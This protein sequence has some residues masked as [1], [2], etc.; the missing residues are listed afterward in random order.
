[1]KKFILLVFMSFSMLTANA[2]KANIDVDLLSDI[3]SKKQDEIKKKVLSEIVVR[4]IKTSNYVSYT[5]LYNMLNVLL[6]EKNK[7]VIQQRVIL[8]MSSFAIGIVTYNLFLKD[9]TGLY[10]EFNF[11]SLTEGISGLSPKAK[12]E[13]E[14]LRTELSSGSINLKKIIELKKIYPEIA[15]K[16]LPG[17]L[18]E[19]RRKVLFSFDYF[20]SKII[21]LPFM[22]EKKLV[23]PDF[24]FFSQGIRDYNMKEMK[25][26][27]PQLVASIDACIA[28]FEEKIALIE[29]YTGAANTLIGEARDFYNNFKGD[30]LR[31]ASNKVAVI[32]LVKLFQLGYEVYKDFKQPEGE[33][34]NIFIAKIGEIIS[35]YVI[36]DLSELETKDGAYHFKIDVEGIILALQ[37]AF[38][39]LNIHISSIRKHTIGVDPFFTIGFNY[40][41]FNIDS[42]NIENNLVPIKSDVG[43]ASEK[44]GIKFI[45]SD[46]KYT[47]SFGVN[48]PYKYRGENRS[49]NYPHKFSFFNKLYSCIYISGILYNIVN[50]KTD[51]NFDYPITGANFGFTMFNDL[52]I[53]AGIAMPIL[54]HQHIDTMFESRFFTLSLDIPIFEY[55]AAVKQK[56]DK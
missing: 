53:S 32:H 30:D 7:T 44:L 41:H 12:N 28:R 25:E 23:D 5:M 40:S 20:F 26:K 56:H 14:R 4:N 37:S 8:E 9:T 15:G 1:M 52:D 54:Y 18:D 43:F 35:K 34:D 49:W 48:Q 3:I 2:Q 13:L 36:T 38:P 47:R 27:Y 29:H 6:T 33:G 39:D 19:E 10:H 22:K 11:N 51:N 46:M 31:N 24:V 50:I 45:F 16:K 17:N 42:I 55:I 21:D